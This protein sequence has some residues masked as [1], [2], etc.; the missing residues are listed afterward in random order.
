M[1]KMKNN[2]TSANDSFTDQ[3]DIAGSE[4]E[5]LPLGEKNI[6]RK[7]SKVTALTSIIVISLIGN[8]F[9]VAVT[10]K[11]KR[12]QTATAYKFLVTLPEIWV[13]MADARAHWVVNGGEIV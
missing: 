10:L 13:K 2:S 12:M 4:D 3:D 5:C 9:T 11:T 6:V 1:I 8:V 7:T